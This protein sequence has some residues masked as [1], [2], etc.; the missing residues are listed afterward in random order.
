MAK[1]AAVSQ[2]T[3]SLNYTD[4]A[5]ALRFLAIDAVNA[6]NSGH[7]GMPMGLA[8]VATVLFAKHMRFHPQ[9]PK[10]PNRDRFVLSNGHGSMLQYGLLHLLGYDLPLTEIK[11][12]RQLH[13]HTPGH[14]EYGE[15]IGVETTTGPL[16]QGMATAVG[17]ALG[18][19]LMAARYG[20]DI[21]NNKTYVIVG[22]GCLMEGIS[23][24]AAEMAARWNLS[25]LI[26]LFD[27]N[28]IT[29]DGKADLAVSTN[30]I[31]RFESYGF[32]TRRCDGHDADDIDT[33]LAWA[34]K[35][36]K[37]VF[38]A[39]RTRIGHG[40][41]NMADSA[42]VHGS[43]LGEAEAEA[44]RKA[45]GWTHAPFDIP[46]SIRADWK[47]AAEHGKRDCA[48][49]DD[50]FQSLPAD[51]RKAI[52]NGLDLKIDDAVFKALHA[53]ERKAVSEKPSVATRKASGNCLDVVTPLMPT[54]VS[55]SA[56]LTGSNNTWTPSS[57]SLTPT[58]FAA[59]YIHYG[60]REHAM[61]AVM[62]GIALYGGLRPISGTFLAFLDY[63]RPAV[64]LAALMKLP[65]VHVLTHDSI[66]LG[67][68]G[69]THQPVEHLATLRAMPN[70][71]SFRPAD[72]VET[73]ECWEAA[74]RNTTGP[75]ALILSRQNLPTVR[76]MYSE[77]VPSARG[78][79]VLRHC[80]GKAVGIF[81]ASG[82][83]VHIA[84]KAH[85][86]LKAKGIDIRV[87]SMPS[88]ELFLRQDKAYRDSVLPAN[89]TAR[90]GIEA[91]SPF[92]WAEVLGS[93]GVFIGMR[94]FGASA[95]ADELYKHFGITVEDACRTMEKLIK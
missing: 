95:P 38:I 57:T 25:N 76:E 14:P 18:Q 74:L 12:F 45:L 75:S 83:E 94:G 47:E 19:K 71:T 82:S 70:M 5:N 46:Q 59:N 67:E 22:D 90:V 2:Q 55:G 91:A 20:D 66:G 86:A 92:G 32:T 27:D 23:H 40:S 36:D 85:E 61:A 89:L 51:K 29:I 53:L 31:K 11:N 64:R 9:R 77:E 54:L 43:P 16:G 56:D 39:C 30:H 84:V 52:E 63:M 34:R 87:V 79:Y 13:S 62:N 49:W 33:A 44:T 48:A 42:K 69:P 35:Q 4:M 28:N 68:D 88:M 80:D 17:M 24:E 7:P 26:V 41:P 81:I 6:A 37:P 72:Q 1:T 8:D 60:V 65:V 21:F 50:A 78:G 3:P 10:W 93:H 15:T 58:N 73:A